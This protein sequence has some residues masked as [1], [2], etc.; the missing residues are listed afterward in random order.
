MLGFLRSPNLLRCWVSCVHPTYSWCCRG[1]K[2]GFP[3]L[4][5]LQL[6]Q[7]SSRDR[8]LLVGWELL[9]LGDR[10]LK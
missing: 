5:I 4:L 2:T 3:F 9:D 10:L 7:K 1:S 6:C 8:I